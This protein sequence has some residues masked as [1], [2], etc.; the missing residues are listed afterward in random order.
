[1]GIMQLDGECTVDEQSVRRWKGTYY[2]YKPVFLLI[3]P[4]QQI[5]NIGSDNAM[6]M[7]LK[8]LKNIFPIFNDTKLGYSLQLGVAS[9]WVLMIGTYSEP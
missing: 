6:L 8:N 1:M 7:H 5:C 2:I 4:I 9:M 3:G